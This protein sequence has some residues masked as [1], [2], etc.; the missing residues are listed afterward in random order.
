MAETAED[1]DTG[2]GVK[3]ARKTGASTY[4][5]FAEVTDITQPEETRD[6]VEFTHHK[7][8]DGYKEFK[9]SKLTD[10]GELTVVYNYI[11]AEADDETVQAHF[12]TKAVEDWR[13]IYP[14]GA[15][16]DFRGFVTSKQPTTPIDDRMTG[17][18][19]FKL[20]GKPV[21]TPAA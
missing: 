2:F 6:P 20:T 19:T 13:V 15:T 18:A 12:A 11:P 8:P 16:F 7:S 21:L 5:E 3:F 14:N 9:P 1:T 4:T 17:S 10:A